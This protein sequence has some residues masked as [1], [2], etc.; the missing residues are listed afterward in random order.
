MTTRLFVT[1]ISDTNT[2]YLATC[3]A[4]V[5]HNPIY[6]GMDL[7]QGDC[8]ARTLNLPGLGPVNIIPITVCTIQHVDGKPQIPSDIQIQNIANAYMSQLQ[9][10]PQFADIVASETVTLGTFDELSPML[11]IHVYVTQDPIYGNLKFIIIKCFVP[12][13]INLD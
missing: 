6:P 2:S 7:A 11:N 3:N 9:I 13:Q 10:H 8:I 4:I 1:T 12:Y 5:A